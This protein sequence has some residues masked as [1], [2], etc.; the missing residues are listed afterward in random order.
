MGN[1]TKKILVAILLLTLF[2]ATLPAPAHAEIWGES[3]Y[4]AMYLKQTLEEMY[5]KIQQTI[6]ANLRMMAMRVI[7]TKLMSI[8]G[9]AGG[10]GGPKVIGDWRQ[11]IYGAAMTYSMQATNDFFRG[12]QSGLP[13]PM[14]RRIVMPAQRSVMANPYSIQPDLQ[15][16]VREG[17]AEMI[18]R[19]GWAPN[20]WAAWRQSFMPQNDAGMIA[21]QGQ[22]LKQASFDQQA[23]VKK[24]EGVAGAGFE[25]TK[26]GA[27]PGKPDSGQITMSGSA[28]KDMAV[29]VQSMPIDM[30]SMARSIPD[31]VSSMVTTMLTQM[32]NQG[33]NMANMKINQVANQIAVP[34]IQSQIQKGIR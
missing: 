32:L 13:S 27:T 19:Q 26:K 15:N 25:G 23:E 28:A 30:I 6:V 20:Q 11:F 21:L 4:G 31:V 8:F 24:A 22:A 29:K 9:G 1:K 33:F 34:N 18:F 17:R 12:M 10:A 7:Q 14:V 16:Y 5:N 3:I 2:T